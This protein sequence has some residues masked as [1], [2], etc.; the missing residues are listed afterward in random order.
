[1]REPVKGTTTAGRRRE[2]RARDTRRHIVDAAVRLFLDRGYVATTV[3]AIAQEAGVA[4]ATVYQAFGTK[5]DILATALDWTIGGDDA[6]LKV[7]DRD[8]VGAARQEPDPRRRLRMIVSG[9]ALVA[10]RTAPL[11]VVM[12]DAAAAEPSAGVLVRQDHERR[13]RTQAGLVDLLIDSQPLRPGLR[14]GKAVDTFFALV[15][16]VTYD[17]LVVQRGWTLAAWQ[18]WLCRMV[19]LELFGAPANR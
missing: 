18:E 15:N 1:M 12:R 17:L 16:S 2:A 4:A 13:H 11:K 19:E 7:L 3:Q 9:A 5:T 8:W 10:A 14:R 6:P